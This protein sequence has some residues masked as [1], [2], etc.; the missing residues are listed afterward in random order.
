MDFEGRLKAGMLEDRDQKLEALSRQTMQQRRVFQQQME[1]VEGK[2]QATEEERD[3]LMQRLEEL[4]EKYASTLK[5]KEKA[6]ANLKQEQEKKSVIGGGGGDVGG[7]SSGRGRGSLRE[8]DN[9]AL[10]R[11]QDQL[12]TLKR[13]RDR[14]RHDLQDARSVHAEALKQARHEL[15]TALESNATLQLEL[16]GRELQH[17]STRRDYLALQAELS[18]N[19]GM[20]V[21]QREAENRLRDREAKIRSLEKEL[22]TLATQRDQLR[23]KLEETWNRAAAGMLNVPGPGEVA[24]APPRLG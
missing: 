12:A 8:K 6:V 20:V 16:N 19:E 13:E 23:G 3:V 14:L 17:Q 22:I 7:S 9:D 1:R 24:T 15:A 21:L 11:A 4:V 2:L 18:K 5:A 10:A